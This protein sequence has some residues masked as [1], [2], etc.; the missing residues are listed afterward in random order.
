MRDLFMRNDLLGGWT[1]RGYGLARV[2]LAVTA[3]LLAAI[4]AAACCQLFQWPLGPLD[5]SLLIG[6]A[7]CT[8]AACLLLRQHRRPAPHAAFPTA[9]WAAA[10]RAC[11]ARSSSPRI[12]ANIGAAADTLAEHFAGETGVRMLAALTAPH[13]LRPEDGIYGLVERTRWLDAQWMHDHA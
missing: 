6:A 3:S 9:Q 8:A 11:D 4:L 2:M 13:G 5:T 1:H 10:M 12:G 7:S